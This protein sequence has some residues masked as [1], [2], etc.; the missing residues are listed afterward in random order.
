MYGNRL[1]ISAFIIL[2]FAMIPVL[3]FASGAGG[4]HAGTDKPINHQ[5]TELVIQLAIILFAT[6]IGGMLAGKIGLPGVVGQLLMGIVIGPFLLGKLAFPGF[7]EGLFPL[8]AGTIPVTPQI[9]SLST[10]A[11]IVLLFVAGLETDLYIFLKYAAKGSIVGIGGVLVSFF[12]GAWL[13]TLFTDYTLMHPVTLFMGTMSVATSVG[14]T[15]SILSEKRKMDSPEGVVILSA[16]VIDDVM[17]III[18]AVVLGIATIVPASHSVSNDAAAAIHWGSIAMVGLKAV[19]VWLLFT[20]LG[21]VFSRPLGRFLKNTFKDQSLVTVMAFGLALLL[22]GIFES[23]GLS[24]IIG[25]YIIGLSLSNTDLAYMIQSRLKTI[26]DLLV[27]VFF[28]VSGMMVNLDV[29]MSWD[30]ISFGLIFTAVAIVAKIVGSGGA[31]LFLNFNSLGAARIGLGMVPRGEVALIMAGIGMSAGIINEQQFGVALLMTI[32]STVLAPPIL[33][34]ILD[35][36]KSGQRIEEA[37]NEKT[38]TTFSFQ[39]PEFAQLV[40]T[41]FIS[42][43]EQEGFFVNNMEHG[44]EVIQMRKDDIFIS[45]YIE[46]DGRATFLSDVQ[47]VHLFKTAVYESLLM[48]TQAASELKKIFQPDR[49]AK[50]LSQGEGRQAFDL[51]PYTATENVILKLNAETKEDLIREMLDHALENELI[52]DYD[53]VLQDILDRERSMT[54]GM[55]H[56]IAIPHTKSEGVEQINFL[57][58]IKQEG[59]DFEAMDGQPS[60]IF[61]MIL[62]PAQ[63][64]GPHIQLMSTITGLLNK[65]SV[66]TEILQAETKREVLRILKRSQQEL[67][68]GKA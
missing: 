14:I 15:A 23:V 43:M 21:L 34:K 16:A 28:A 27:P 68:K 54:T 41:K 62:T 3:L 49:M 56:G 29:L 10:L 48:V 33:N 22:A 8:A 37:K 5:M 57:I 64:H 60:N 66:R 55:A 40:I 1:K 63:K 9:Y 25:A 47:D 35:V 12:T 24:M 4:A 65:E 45:L 2:F 51:L 30:V 42:L 36:P 18:L 53:R 11:A 32:L 20:I 26:H 61:I 52:R 19:G 17:G 59:I 67:A 6:W 46:N 31:A 50:A 44:E 39:S 7:P 38:E 13:T 58:G